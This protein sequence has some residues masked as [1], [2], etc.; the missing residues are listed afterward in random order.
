MPVGNSTNNG[1]ATIFN[2]VTTSP[3]SMSVNS[4]MAIRIGT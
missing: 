3:G 1:P 4:A 2:G